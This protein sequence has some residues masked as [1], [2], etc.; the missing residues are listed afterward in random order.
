MLKGKTVVVGVSG[1]IAAYKAVALCS[2]LTQAGANVR[3]IMTEGAAKFVTPLTFQSITRHAVYTDTFDEQD[4]SVIAHIDLADRA[5][6]IVVAPATANVI[7]KMAHGLADDMLTTT[8]L[9][10]TC[11]IV[12]A[13]A[14]NVHMY[15]HPAVVEN[16]NTL[17]LRGIRFV[18][19]GTGQLACGYVGK[20]RLAEPEQIA[21]YL[22]Q[23]VMENEP[24]K[25]LAGK[26]VLIT[27]G[28]TVERI[29]PVR[30]IT[31]DSSGKMGFAIA[32][33]AR[34]LGA[35]VTL[36]YASV[37]EKLPEGVEL[38]RVQSALDM[39]DAVLERFSDTDLVVK[40]AA[41]ADYRPAEP[42]AQKIKKQEDELTLRL[43][44]NPDILAAL[45]Q[46]K[47]KQFL[48]GFAAETNDLELHAMQKL[49]RKN[50]DL[51]VAND[52]T[53]PLAGFGKDTNV[54]HVFDGNGPA[55]SF[56]PLSKHEAA[57]RLLLLT[58]E[59]MGCGRPAGGNE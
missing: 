46:R 20:G 9:A 48:V 1:G 4:A 31:N 43:V 5:D 33:Q 14:M 2:R 40:A 55:A 37:S 34:R 27:A 41:V 23:L 39:M 26:R 50:C 22:E 57:L 52:V 19:P 42:A 53:D 15:E 47:T 17:R 51:I 6:L 44:K 24:P 45:G 58:A 3:V 13:P 30:Y 12:V 8:L 28:G 18:E 29:D 56:P 7:A 16:M 49:Q 38:V 59:R 11:P 36:V 10:A 25:L 54:L 35:E 21:A 32:E